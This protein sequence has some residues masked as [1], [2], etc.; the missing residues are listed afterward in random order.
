MNI[1]TAANEL[2]HDATVAPSRCCHQ[3]W[4]RP[5]PRQV[6]HNVVDL[7]GWTTQALERPCRAHASSKRQKNSPSLTH[8]VSVQLASATTTLMTSTQS[9]RNAAKQNLPD[10][11][12]SGAERPKTRVLIVDPVP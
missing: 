6:W 4:D 5:S 11:A 8:A 10:A 3:W 7:Q 1:G 9:P 12:M 2:K